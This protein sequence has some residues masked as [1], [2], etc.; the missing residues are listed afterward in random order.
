MLN[1]Q[2][3]QTNHLTAKQDFSGSS[4]YRE[5]INHLILTGAL[6]KAETQ[7]RAVIALERSSASERASLLLYLSI[8]QIKYAEYYGAKEKLTIAKGLIEEALALFG[9]EVSEAIKLD[10]YI[11][12]AKIYRLSE[13]FTRS[14]QLYK[15]TLQLSQVYH[16]AAGETKAALGLGKAAL[17]KGEIEEA[18]EFGFRALKILENKPNDILL[19]ETYNL[20]GRSYIK[21]RLL[22][23]AKQYFKRA[24]SLSAAQR[25]IEANINSQ[26][27]IAVLHAM[28]NEYQEAMEYF[29]E[30]LEKSKIIK[31]RTH[32]AHCLINIGTIHA[33]LLNFTEA[34]NRYSTA[35]A[36]YQDVL[37]IRNQ[38]ILLNNIGN[39]YHTTKKYDT[40]LTYFS[41]V[42]ALA[43]KI[44]Y[45][46]MIAHAY[47]QLSK[48]YIAKENFKNATI[49]ALKSQE[50]YKV[51]GDSKERHSNF[52]NLAQIAF[53]EQDFE[54][55]IHWA[56][57]CL[58]KAR[59]FKDNYYLLKSSKL[60]ADIH[61]ANDD[62]RQSSQY[63]K[64]YASYQEEWYKDQKVRQTLDAEIR[65]AI[66]EKEKA[67]EVL[68]KENEYNSLLIDQNEQMEAQNEK[69]RYINEELKQFAYVVSHDLKEPMRMIV[70]YTQLLER[71]YLQNLDEEAALYFGFVKDGATRMNKLLRDLLE[72]ATIGRN[73]E[74]IIKNDMND[75]VE[76]VIENLLMKIEET[77]TLIQYDDLPNIQAEK[78]L[79]MQL[80]Q[81][82]ISNAIK[83]RGTET[84]YIIIRAKEEADHILFSVTDNGIG[85][86]DQYQE[87]IFVMFQRLNNRKDYEGSGIGLSIC[88]KI[89]HKLGGRI[90]LKSKE[91]IGTTFYFTLSK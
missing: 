6:K 68:R 87:R 47:S 37:D 84:P 40:A 83:F 18:L 35:I 28:N 81:N 49:Y 25:Y 74:N 32:T 20:I 19:I 42:L 44:E 31:H 30:A 89:V 57:Q 24:L 23:K 61:E 10:Y 27:N 43:T 76:E 63:Y 4:D 39:T 67:I 73:E 45:R 51:I 72:Y 70:S 75:V 64:L 62:F 88:Q 59:L 1:S 3:E 58:E 8:I 91:G 66:K 82:L 38:V 41:K 78:S 13:E 34:L 36:I 71:K 55:A 46:Q 17:E 50:A 33:H 90:W 14:I 69:L 21:K 79:L 54:K 85:I 77:D 80:F 60:I 53:A 15:K 26:K 11:E 12:L 48:T 65:Y 56:N 7:I 86:G 16:E 5:Q 29:L 9:T 52:M 2:F 22:P